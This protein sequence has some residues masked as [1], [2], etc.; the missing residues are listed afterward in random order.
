MEGQARAS[1]PSQPGCLLWPTSW[2]ALQEPRC[3]GPRRMPGPGLHSEAGVH[4]GAPS[5]H[6]RGA[7][8]QP[9]AS[10]AGPREAVGTDA[11]GATEG[12]RGTAAST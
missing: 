7:C 6:V 2:G 5:P 4:K 8:P 3:A 1:V 12:S 9:G 11:S 10:S